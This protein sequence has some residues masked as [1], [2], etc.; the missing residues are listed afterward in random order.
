MGT[1]ADLLGLNTFSAREVDVEAGLNVIGRSNFYDDARFNATT[2]INENLIL[3]GEE[4]KVSGK[5]IS[6]LEGITDNVQSQLDQKQGNLEAGSNITIEDGVISSDP[7]ARSLDELSD[8]STSG[9]FNTGIGEGSLSGVT[10]GTEN[11]GVG[12]LALSSMKTG[13]LNVAVGVNS[14][15]DGQSGSMNVTVGNHSLHRNISGS[16]N[17]AIGADAL[18]L[19]DGNSNVAVGGR[20]GAG[21]DVGYNNTY[22]G[23]NVKPSNSEV[24]N[25]IAIGSNATGSGANTAVIGNSNLNTIYAG[26]EGQAV[27]VAS[28][29]YIT[30]AGDGLNNL[31]TTTTDAVNQAVTRFEEAEKVL[32]N[33]VEAEA[34]K[35]DPISAGKIICILMEK[36]IP[37]D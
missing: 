7:G 36:L 15:R 13:K 26:Q 2:L 18:S 14:Q 29:V 35:Q 32:A 30:E 20:A 12:F 24:N 33:T 9:N 34:N 17:V 4:V 27:V 1:K 31:I 23:S 10:T 37:L 11:T 21:L 8:A 28:D 5:E 16:N 22:L 6:Q 25:E 3:K 19:T